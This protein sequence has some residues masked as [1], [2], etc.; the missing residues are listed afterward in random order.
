MNDLSDFQEQLDRL[1]TTWLWGGILGCGGCKALT[2]VEREHVCLVCGRM[3]CGGC[4]KFCDYHRIYFLPE[5]L[6]QA[7][8]VDESR[9]CSLVPDDT[10]VFT[11]DNS[12]L[13]SPIDI[14]LKLFEIEFLGKIFRVWAGNFD[15]WKVV[16]YWVEG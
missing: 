3:L 9:V 10:E 12:S 4:G 16:Y 5:F 8:G 14:P 2:H 6:Q 7:F 11:I 1:N 13:I 15:V